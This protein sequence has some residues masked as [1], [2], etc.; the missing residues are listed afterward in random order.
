MGSQ[1]PPVADARH[2]LLIAGTGRAGT[3]FLV[4]VL[5]ACGLDTELSRNPHAGYDRA[6]QAG[7]ESDPLVPKDHPYVVK[8]PWAYQF[9]DQFL[10]DPGLHLDGAILPIRDLKEAVASRLALELGHIYGLPGTARLDAPWREFGTVPGGAAHSLEPLDQ[11]RILAHGLH[12]LLE[13]LLEHDVPIVMMKFPRFA[14]DLDYLY[15]H[16]RP[17]LP[18]G[19]EAGDFRAAVA[20]VVD[21]ARIRV[22]REIGRKPADAL[23]T[24]EEIERIA[25]KRQ[26]VALQDRLDRYAW[27]DR[28]LKLAERLRRRMRQAIA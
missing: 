13:R 21:P 20:P 11:A 12:L 27:I 15:A 8:S 5:T 18:A 10:A 16:L 26:V 28:P 23:P 24:P 9:V 14:E 25:L 17:F 22:G 6:A 7:L 1:Q 19:M 2:H 3:T 4:E